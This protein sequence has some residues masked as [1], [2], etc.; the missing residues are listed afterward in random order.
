MVGAWAVPTA[1]AQS[2]LQ[3][4]SQLE[5]FNCSIRDGSGRT[6]SIRLNRVERGIMVRGELVTIYLEHIIQQHEYQRVSSMLG[7]LGRNTLTLQP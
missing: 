7:E 4:V 5:L 2:V 3:E 1:I 6:R